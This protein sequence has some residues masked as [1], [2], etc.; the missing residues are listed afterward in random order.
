[1][2]VQKIFLLL[3][4]L[5]SVFPFHMIL[6]I[7]EN[8]IYILFKLNKKN[9]SSPGNVDNSTSLRPLGDTTTTTLSRDDM[10]KEIIEHK[11]KITTN[12]KP[13]ITLSNAIA[14][15]LADAS[16]AQKVNMYDGATKLVRQS[17]QENKSSQGGRGGEELPD[18]VVFSCSHNLPRYYM[19]ETVVPEFQSR[20]GELPEPLIRTGEILSTYY[21]QTGIKIPMACPYCVYNNLRKEQLQIM[22][23]TGIEMMNTKS[24]LWEI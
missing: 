23:E 18:S 1:M 16:V 5:L 6:T 9:H 20:M 24:T 11:R 3:F 8:N 12:I 4:G 17:S 7:R 13:F 21:Q 2:C 10:A 19:L 15:T 22:R 14:T